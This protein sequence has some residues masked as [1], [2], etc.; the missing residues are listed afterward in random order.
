MVAALSAVALGCGG[1]VPRSD[2]L[3]PAAEIAL[4]PRFT[5]APTGLYGQ[6]RG[7]SL[8]P[9]DGLR[10]VR[11]L[12]SAPILVAPVE[13]Q[14]FGEA[15]RC[16]GDS[17]TARSVFFKTTSSIERGDAILISFSSRQLGSLTPDPE[18]IIEVRLETTR[19]SRAALVHQ[20][21]RVGS[22]W[23]Q[24]FVPLIAPARV[25]AGDAE[26]V[27]RLSPGQHGLELGGVSAHNYGLA[28]TLADLPRMPT[29]YAGMEPEASWRARAA[30]SI[31][32]TRKGE[33]SVV[34]TRADGEPVVGAD[35]VVHQTRSHFGFGTAASAELLLTPSASTYRQHL[36][37]SFNLVT[38]END[39][40]WP[41]LA[42]DWGE[43]FT[44][45]RVDEA[46]GWLSKQHIDVRGTSLVWPAW[47]HVPAT[48]RRLENDPGKLGA[49][50]E[51]HIT[52][53][54]AALHGRL[55]SWDVVNNPINGR[56]ITDLLG[57]DSIE[58]WLRT[59]RA[60][61]ATVKLAVSQ[62]GVLAT[63]TGADWHRDEL[64]RILSHL[65]KR[66]AP[67]DAIGLHAHFD[68]VSLTSPEKLLATLDQLARLGRPI[69]VTELSINLQDEAL[70]AR[71]AEDFYTAMFSHPAVDA[72]V[73]WGFWDGAASNGNALLHRTDWSL[74]PAG[75]SYLGITQKRWRT[76]AKLTTNA[77]G[78]A[79]VRAFLGDYDLEVTSGDKRKRLSTTLG[80]GGA[81]I[82]VTLE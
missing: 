75:A 82:T 27:F 3:E 33:L 34:V 18:A 36:V 13:G 10:G 44:R 76:D 30:E 14:A 24:A 31:E 55:A 49:A 67:L 43:G 29:T 80:P 16:R 41:A 2:D 65:I 78:Q 81:A 57:A 66:G 40:K 72:V 12:E 20:R 11:P 54:A 51:E 26:L 4:A 7:Q 50:I 22:A 56:A 45:R 9:A 52:E 46:L 35:V 21:V 69:Y 32:R 77:Q 79:T 17:G 1:P 71:Y 15:I 63:N 61:D 58:H 39:L 53:V 47:P 5:A 68:A 8:L 70:T 74:K 42:G 37:N 25:R 73:M 62:D 28:L 38:L 23:Q 48:L 64:E 6:V 19:G 59:A 60:A